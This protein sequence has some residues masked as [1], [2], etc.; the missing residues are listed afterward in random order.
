MYVRRK[1]WRVLHGVVLMVVTLWSENWLQNLAKGH[2]DYCS[3][4]I[5]TNALENLTE[6]VSVKN[7]V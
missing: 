7:L 5:W 6:K 3:Q 4:F 2:I 1:H